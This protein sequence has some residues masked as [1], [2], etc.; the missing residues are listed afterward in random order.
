MSANTYDDITAA[1]SI[2]TTLGVS[3]GSKCHISFNVM[4]ERSVTE[5]LTMREFRIGK[6]WIE[7]EFDRD[8]KSEMLSSPTH[9]TFVSALIQMQKVTYVYC[10]SKFGFPIDVAGNEC[11][12]VWPT[13][14]HISMPGMV[15]IES[16]LVHRM[17]FIGFRKIEPRK[18]LAIAKS[19][20]SNTLEINASAII[21]LL[22]EP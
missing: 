18:Y 17:D 6:T 19:N 13:D 4:P 8:Y 10:C 14:V 7:A 9:L 12:K 11:L 15:T 22:Q 2:D 1:N 16:G 21:Q 5:E 3:D 20:I